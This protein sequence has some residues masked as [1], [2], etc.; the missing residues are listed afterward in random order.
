MSL[1]GNLIK[2][3]IDTTVR[4][5]VAVVKDVAT[6]G[7]AIIDEDSAIVKTVK[8]TTEDVGDVVDDL[9]DL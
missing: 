1:F 6:L 7:G 2:V 9:E 3:A 5:P 8:K 4:L